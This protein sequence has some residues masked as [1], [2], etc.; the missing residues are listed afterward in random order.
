[1]SV[2]GTLRPIPTLRHIRT[3]RSI[4]TN[5]GPGRGLWLRLQ[6][7]EQRRGALKRLAHPPSPALPPQKAF[8]DERR[9]RGGGRGPAPAATS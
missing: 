6:E 5:T 2:F 7:T 9:G 1:M 8:L 3:M 4:S